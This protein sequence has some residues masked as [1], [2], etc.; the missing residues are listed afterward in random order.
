MFFWIYWID[1]VFGEFVCDLVINN[2][3]KFGFEL[4][5][6]CLYIRNVVENIGGR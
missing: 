2:I 4:K 5:Y 1:V 6:C 3:I